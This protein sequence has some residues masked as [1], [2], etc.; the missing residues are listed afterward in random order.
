[1]AEAEYEVSNR[2]FD[3]DEEVIK[4]LLNDDGLVVIGTGSFGTCYHSSALKVVFKV[5]ND[6]LDCQDERK[7]TRDIVSQFGTDDFIQRYTCFLDDDE[8]NE[9]LGGLKLARWTLEDVK[10]LVC[11]YKSGVECN[12]L[13]NVLEAVQTGTELPMRIPLES[14]PALLDELPVMFEAFIKFSVKHHVYHCDIKPENIFVVKTEGN[15][16]K[17]QLGDWGHAVIAEKTLSDP[18]YSRNIGTFMYSGLP[19]HM[20]AISRLI[21]METPG[22]QD[23]VKRIF[24]LRKEEIPGLYGYAQKTLTQE[25]CKLWGTMMSKRYKEAVL[26]E[27]V[28]DDGKQVQYVTFKHPYLRD[29][30]SMVSCFNLVRLATKQPNTTFVNQFVNQLIE[31]IQSN[32]LRGPEGGPKTTMEWTEATSKNLFGDFEAVANDNEDADDNDNEEDVESPKKRA[33]VTTGGNNV[34][35]YLDDEDI[36]QCKTIIEA[37]VVLEDNNMWKRGRNIISKTPTEGGNPKTRGHWRA[38]ASLLLGLTMTA[39]TVLQ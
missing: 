9:V 25:I 23:R 36:S 10:R 16:F 22:G 13:F 2:L 26:T 21:A 15:V 37:N 8:E 28:H 24:G 34:P 32:G 7:A 29:L 38:L 35:S 17:L 27:T 5:F 4:G 6:N 20:V 19:L 3:D 30:Y 1:M 31:N 14:L 12:D 11:V 33:K 39:I 18:D